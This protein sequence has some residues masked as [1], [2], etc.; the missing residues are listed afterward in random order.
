MPEPVEKDREPNHR[1]VGVATVLVVAINRDRF[2]MHRTESNATVVNVAMNSGVV[3]D[4]G[5]SRLKPHDTYRDHGRCGG[6]Y[7][8]AHQGTHGVVLDVVAAIWRP[9]LI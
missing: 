2:T 8:A 5:S 4:C 9:P 6:S 7:R 1:T 3:P